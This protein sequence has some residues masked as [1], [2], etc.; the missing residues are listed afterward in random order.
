MN[1]PLFLGPMLGIMA[2]FVLLVL[3]LIGTYFEK[4]VRE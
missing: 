2:G 3:W 4:G 1:N